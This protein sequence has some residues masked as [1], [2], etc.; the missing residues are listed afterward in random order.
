MAQGG[1]TPDREK[2]DN[3]FCPAWWRRTDSLS[4]ETLS[5][6]LLSHYLTLPV[7][8]EEGHPVGWADWAPKAAT[9]AIVGGACPSL[10]A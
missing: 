6:N 3:D 4:M 8:W 2:A 5:Q 9:E 7:L 1:K 10:P